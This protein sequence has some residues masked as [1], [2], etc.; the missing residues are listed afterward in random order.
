M[1]IGLSSFR[2]GRCRVGLPH[3]RHNLLDGRFEKNALLGNL[4]TVYQDCEF[5]PASV[6]QRYFD[7]RLLLQGS[8]QTG[9]VLTDAASD[10]ALPDDYVLHGMH[11]FYVK[12]TDGERLSQ[13]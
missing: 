12:P 6:H 9:G 7:S 11:S 13:R 5:A 10:W 1:R 4:P 2:L 8:R 3:G